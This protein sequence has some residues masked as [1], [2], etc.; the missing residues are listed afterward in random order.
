MTSSADSTAS[1]VLSV[2]LP[3]PDRL[4]LVER[5]VACLGQQSLASQMEL[6]LVAE[7]PDAGLP[8]ALTAP[9]GWVQIVARPA[10]TTMTEARVA[11]VLHARAPIVALCEDHCFPAPGWA[12]ALL[13]AH[14]GPWAA[15]G[16]AF[17]NANP[18]TRI[19]WANLAIEYG[20]WLHPVRPGA[21]SHVPG[22]NSSYKRSLLLAY[23]GRLSEM[24]EAE[25]V[26]HWDLQRHGHGVAMEPDARTRH[27]NFSRFR[28]SI[29]LRFSSGRL[30]AAS[31][32]LE[33]P[34]WRKAVFAIG[35]GVLPFLRSW[36]AL[37]DLRRV[38]DT[39]PRR[40][41]SLVIFTLLVFDALGEVIGYA[42]GAGDQ[43]R[44]LS[45]IEH[46]R[47]RFMSARDRAAVRG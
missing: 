7:H 43:S 15:V 26:L 36:R 10:W 8:A 13:T 47:E 18:V 14:E 29:L 11:G 12:E 21:C 37:R 34:W 4:A 20:P 2:I 35:S 22:H 17:L 6:I 38:Q 46:D 45:E 39:R 23:G 28:P 27:E 42:I 40:G 25:S 16:P 24:L 1:P 19:S 9:F 30:F 3:A 33:W 32:A 5:V 41:L 31:R 44:R